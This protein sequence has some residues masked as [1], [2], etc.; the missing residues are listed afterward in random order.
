MNVKVTWLTDADGTLWYENPMIPS[1]METSRFISKYSNLTATEVFDYLIK[2]HE[3]RLFNGEYIGAYDWESITMYTIERVCDDKS[4]M[5]KALRVLYEAFHENLSHIK[6]LDDVLEA[7]KYA[8]ENNISIVIVSN[9]LGKYMDKVLEASG[10]SKFIDDIVTPDRVRAYWA[11]PIKPFRPIFIQ[12]MKLAPANRYVMIGN[13]LLFDI[14][15][16]LRSGVDKAYI[17][18]QRARDN[19]EEA[20]RVAKALDKEVNVQL[21]GSILKSLEIIIS[22]NKNNKNTLFTYVNT[23]NEIIIYEEGMGILRKPY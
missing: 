15:G 12:A 14:I 2:V 11:P 4:I 3:Y 23:W 1:L 13:N 19:L 16:A 20:V 21:D 22:K 9:G 10:L 7:L 18:R 5:S 17:I 6:L 8:K